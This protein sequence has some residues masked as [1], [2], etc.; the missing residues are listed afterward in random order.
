VKQNNWKIEELKNYWGKPLSQ[1][2]VKGADGTEQKFNGASIPVEGS[3]DEYENYSEIPADKLPKE[4]DVVKWLNAKILASDKAS[5]TVK[6][7]KDRGFV[8]PTLETDDL[9]QL[10]AVYAGVKASGKSQDE[11]MAIAAQAIGKAWPTGYKP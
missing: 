8:Q 10:K 9:L 1:L 3:C 4:S 7:L 11:A 6:T 5:T 2:M